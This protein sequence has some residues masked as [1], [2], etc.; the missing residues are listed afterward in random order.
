[1]NYKLVS[2]LF[3]NFI[4][5][6]VV[7][8]A[9]SQEPAV[10]DQV[11]AVVA[12]SPILKSDL[13]NQERQL[14]SQGIDFQENSQCRILDDMLYQKLLYNQ[15]I[16]DSVEVSDN[17]VEQVLDRR[18]RFFIQ[19]IGSREQLEAYYGKSI[20]ELKDEFRPMVREQELS[21]MMESQITQDI[22]VTPSEV[23]N[24]FHSLPEDSIPTIESETKLAHITIIPEYEPEEV[25]RTIDRL[26]EIRTRVLQG[27]NFKTMAILY[28]EDPGSA[29]KGGELGFYGRGELYPEFE[30]TAYGL[31]PGEISEIIETEAGYHIIQMIERRGDL[32]NVRHIL[33]QPQISPLQLNQAK[34]KLDSIRDLIVKDSLSFEKAATKFSDDPNKVNGGVVMNPY[35]NTTRFKNDEI[36]QNL[37]FAIEKLEKNDITKPVPF[38]NEDGKQG[39]RIVKIL[40]RIEAHTAN[41][42]SDYDFIQE[43]ALER[44][45]MK[46][47]QNWI[48]K[49]ISTTYVYISDD[50][51]HC[52]F[53]ADWKKSKELTGN[54]K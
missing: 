2:F 39:Y 17:Q 3:L 11:V 1:M 30:A 35:T 43:L 23:R 4:L 51:D 18:L 10:V 13:Y 12:D 29:S 34:N 54:R 46:E 42:Q 38:R 52:Q 50:F 19:Q 8:E 40:D 21:Q 48:N 5:Y 20:E 26:N 14:E 7:D 47:V 45:K 24:F 25:E 6:S 27:E 15:A 32:I 37:F 44:K 33:M 9:Y 28:S 49:K 36:D 41:L 16:L 53:S 31:A 22:R